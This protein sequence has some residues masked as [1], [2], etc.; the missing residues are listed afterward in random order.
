MND[1]ETAVDSANGRVCS[2]TINL[3][4]AAIAVGGVFV[5]PYARTC[6]MEAVAV[7]ACASI[8][9][10]DAMS[11]DTGMYR[12][13][14][15]NARR[16]AESEDLAHNKYVDGLVAADMAGRKTTAIKKRL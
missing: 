5:V 8:D 14:I 12:R 9:D 1:L 11:V 15:A 3:G 13:V 7:T 4:V 2:T 16:L 10:I 6:T